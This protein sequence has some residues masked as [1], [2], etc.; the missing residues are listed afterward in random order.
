MSAHLPGCN[1]SAPTFFGV[2]AGLVSVTGRRQAVY[3]VP[4]GQQIFFDVH[5]LRQPGVGVAGQGLGDRGGC[6]R[7]GQGG[8]EALSERMEPDLSRW[9]YAGRCGVRGDRRGVRAGSEDEVLRGHPGGRGG[10][11]LGQV[12]RKGEVRGSLALCCPR[13]EFDPGVLPQD[14]VPLPEPLHL[15][16]PEPGPGRHPVV[17]APGPEAP[18][19][20]P[21]AEGRGVAGLV[22]L[23]G[24]DHGADL[25]RAEGAASRAV[26]AAEHRDLVKGVQPKVPPAAKPLG[27][28][29]DRGQRVVPGAGAAGVGELEEVV[30]E[31]A[32]AGGDVGERLP[33]AGVRHLLEPGLDRGGVLG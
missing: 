6:P 31:V 28:G 15:Q 3:L 11:P 32:G 27:P 17:E 9:G 23:R 19:A 24:L 30:L 7:G 1:R 20:A 25:L 29:P 16:G 8:D 14:Q 4:E 18:P 26:V 5:P 2:P 33:A 13:R 21:P 10:Q 22:G 12:V